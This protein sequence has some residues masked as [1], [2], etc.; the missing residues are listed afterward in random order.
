[1]NR[2]FA[3]LGIFLFV[4]P[5]VASAQVIT[6]QYL[7]SWGWS[8]TPCTV[9]AG[10]QYGYP[11]T[12]P[13]AYQPSYQYGYA[14]ACVPLSYDSLGRVTQTTCGFTNVS[15]QYY[16]YPSYYYGSMYQSWDRQYYR[17]RDDRNH[18]HDR[19][20]DGYHR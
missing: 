3:V 17:D 20:R 18:D 1:M 14:N 12:Y 10:Y 11:Y 8:S 15:Y 16:S 13:Y 5:F 6:T 4:S 2:I 9:Y 19:D 7:C